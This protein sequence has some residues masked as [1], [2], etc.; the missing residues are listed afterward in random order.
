[1]GRSAWQERPHLNG[2][3]T[4]E[5][6]ILAHS[7]SQ[8]I[9]V[10]APW[11]G[12]PGVHNVPEKPWPAPNVPMGDLVSY[13]DGPNLWRRFFGTI[14]PQDDFILHFP[15]Q[16]VADVD[17]DGKKKEIVA[18][19][20][21]D[22]WNLKV[23]DGMTGAEKLSLPDV[24]PPAQ[25]FD[26]DGDGASEMVVYQKN[27]LVI[28]S[29]RDGHW[30][31]RMRLNGGR[32]CLS[33]RPVCTEQP[34]ET[35]RVEQQPVSLGHGKNKSWV[36]TREV[37][38][39]GARGELV[40]IDSRPETNFTVTKVPI[41]NPANLQVLATTADRLI[42]STPDGRIEVIDSKGEIQAQWDCGT[43]FIS[44]PAV[45]DIDGDGTNELV[46]CTADR[47]VVALG[48]A[49]DPRSP[50]KVLWK[51]GGNGLET[52]YPSP[53][54]TP[55]VKDLDGNG[56]KEILVVAD[57]TRLLDCRGKTLWRSPVS[58]SRATFGDFNG[59]GH[60]DV[61]VAAWA[62]VKNSIG[63]TI[64][65]FALDGRNGTELWHNDGSAKEIWHHQLGP[66]HRLP[67]VADVN[68]DGIDDV[69]FV[70]MDLLVTLDGKDGSFMQPPVIA[71]EIW[72]QQ[73]GKDGQWTA[74]GT[75]IPLDVNGDGKRDILLAASWGQWGAWTM[76]RKLLWTFN[77]DK[78][79]L[80]QRGPGI[81]DVDGDGKLEIGVIHDGGIFRCYDATSGNLKWELHGI[82]Q[83]TDAATA[84][85]DGDGRPEFIAGFAAIKAVD[86]THGRVL[87]D[88]DVPAAHSP[89]IADLDGDGLCE[90]ILGCTDGKVRAFK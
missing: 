63:T 17:G 68:G 35:N 50:P 36:A 14:W 56:E 28:G 10:I 41:D 89:V 74:Y 77:P 59:D 40:L 44:E 25:V 23:Y 46:V 31:E 58:A 33:G 51:A 37:A 15:H 48:P 19:V 54:P 76:D 39:D 78:A 4:P 26:F 18:I 79:Q 85:L 57:G 52:S 42:A 72:K 43:P 5:F 8:H 2:D 7:I 90:M 21:K 86:Q 32:L 71:N 80:A 67:T 73:E 38:G 64:Q 45:A 60:L 13:S 88:T 82:K 20:G 87:W 61:Y 47:K 75:Q 9:D 66:L 81:A 3:D 22:S 34:G 83:L 27:A 6:V 53:Y 84:D 1:L 30:S 65:S 16:P 12:S 69:L 49:R 11:R 55:L 70:A 24:A 62:P 29:L